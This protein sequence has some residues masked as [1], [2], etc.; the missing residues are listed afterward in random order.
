MNLPR[1]SVCRE[2]CAIV[3]A[4]KSGRGVSHLCTPTL[5]G[6][7]AALLFS[8]QRV[9]IVTGFF[10]PS[11][12]SSETDGPPGSVALAMSLR[13]L[14][15]HVEIGTDTRNVKALGAAA[16][17]VGFP[18]GKVTDLEK[19]DWQIAPDVLVFIERLGRA[20]DGC[21]YDMRGADV[22]E[23]TAPLDSLAL[24]ASVPVLAI[25]DGGNEVGM[26]NLKDKLR[27]NHSTDGSIQSIVRAD[28]VLPVDVSNWGAYSLAALLALKAKQWVGHT[29]KEEKKMLL[30]LQRQ[31]AVDGVTRKPTLSVDGMEELEHFFVISGLESLMQC[32]LKYSALNSPETS[33]S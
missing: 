9:G 7:A 15:V 17:S 8:A 21:Y 13:R 33:L 11:A 18:L 4:N 28:V 32:E 29:V 24:T 5:W 1:E 22:T 31:G 26:G 23:F 20:H 19:N 2:L 25:G 14:G 3:A 30:A 16:L 27:N 6:Q 12:M 10:I